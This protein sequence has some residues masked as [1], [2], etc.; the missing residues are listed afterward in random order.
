MIAYDAREITMAVSN[1]GALPGQVPPSQTGGMGMQG[2][3][4]RCALAGGSLDVVLEPMF[5]VITKLPVT[6][7]SG[8]I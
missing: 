3:K 5:T 8:I 1:D 6:Q 2:M 4:E 7:R